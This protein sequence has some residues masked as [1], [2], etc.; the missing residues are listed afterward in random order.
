MKSQVDP[1]IL[2]KKGDSFACGLGDG[3]IQIYCL[4]KPYSL[5]IEMKIH[6]SAINSIFESKFGELITGSDDSTIKVSKYNLKDHIFK[7]IKTLKGHESNVYNVIQLEK[8]FTSV[9]YAS[10]SKDQT[11][12]IWNKKAC[13]IIQSY[14]NIEGVWCLLELSNYRIIF[15]QS[16]LYNGLF[17][18]N[19][20]KASI[21]KKNDIVKCIGTNGLC[22]IKIKDK[23]YI[24]IASKGEIHIVDDIH[25]TIQ[26]TFKIDTFTYFWNV[27]FLSD[28]TLLLSGSDE[29]IYHILID[30]GKLISKT[31]IHLDEIP[32]II[33]IK[34][35]IMITCSYDK[36]IKF[37]KLK[38]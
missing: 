20:K 36:T 2:L 17:E 29:Y 16:K 37:W 3:T 7:V 15:C 6:D 21:T 11:I 33:E 25:F 13:Q 38:E 22:K 27:T 24:A 8:R 14:K 31:K 35:N 1:M 4:E 9:L 10:C 30:K 5:Q 19:Y 34:N 18:I 23:N 32:T 28:K 26:N 12:K